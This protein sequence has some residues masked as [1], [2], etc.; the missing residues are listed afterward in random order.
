MEKDLRRGRGTWR[1][2]H[3]FE[4][5]LHEGPSLSTS[6][7]RAGGLKMGGTYWYFVCVSGSS[8]CERLG[9]IWCLVVCARR[10]C[11]IP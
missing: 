9:L 1:G 10:R 4:D 7:K 3:S 8:P 6:K 11:G 5:I 2:C